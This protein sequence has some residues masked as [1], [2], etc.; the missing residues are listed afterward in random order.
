MKISTILPLLAAVTAA[1]FTPIAHAQKPAPKPTETPTATPLKTYG[2]LTPAQ[3]TQL[4]IARETAQKNPAV[5]A[6]LKAQN[7][8]A[9]AMSEAIKAGALEKNPSIAPILQKIHA[10]AQGTAWEKQEENKQWKRMRK[11]WKEQRAKGNKS[12][13]F[14]G[15]DMVHSQDADDL[16]IQERKEYREAR[17]AAAT[18]PTV[19]SAQKKFKK[20][21]KTYDKT[22]RKAMI[23]AD[24]GVKSILSQLGY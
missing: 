6:A 12:D 8:A 11:L 5:I 23:A 4:R 3:R 10:A 15:I 17:K 7:A 18:L 21:K 24:P 9:E 1:N 14:H 20:A 13:Y 16:T 2:T 22:M 19:V